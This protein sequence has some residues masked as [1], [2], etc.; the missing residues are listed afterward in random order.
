M[1]ES[2]GKQN[3]NPGLTER[4]TSTSPLAVAQRAVNNPH[5]GPNGKYVIKTKAQCLDN[6]IIIIIII[7]KVSVFS[8]MGSQWGA[9]VSG[10][11]IQ[12]STQSHPHTHITF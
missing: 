2:T 12:M 5:S 7:F 1:S 9:L 11:Y 4:W 10:I 3:N 6:I 8:L